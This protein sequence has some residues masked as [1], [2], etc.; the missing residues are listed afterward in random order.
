MLY[1]AKR[2]VHPASAKKPSASVA[3][4][5]SDRLH[6]R[7]ERDAAVTL[8]EYGD[9]QCPPC[10]TLSPMID[11]IERDYH[12]RLRVVF[13]NYPLPMHTHAAE[14]AYAAEAAGLQGRF[15]EMHDLLYREQAV[16]TKA[17]DAKTIF[18]GYAGMLGLNAARFNADI[19]SAAVK[20]IV[21]HDHHEGEERGVKSTPTVFINNLMLEPS[22]LTKA[23]LSAAIDSAL[24]ES[25]ATK[26]K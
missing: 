1:R 26:S 10:G 21:E 4:S 23:G 19:Q 7:G 5:S 11:E 2:P 25:S 22:A 13:R 18:N 9:F 3:R 15:W 24:N 8:E 20:N 17:T 12:S 6:I 16:W 14:A